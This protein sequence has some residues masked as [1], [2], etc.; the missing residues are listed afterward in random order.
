MIS[1]LIAAAARF[2]EFNVQP[3][4]YGSPETA[5]QNVKETPEWKALY[6]AGVQL[7]SEKQGLEDQLRRKELEI[8]RL[9]QQV[10][11]LEGAVDSQRGA[12]LETRIVKK[13]LHAQVDRLS[14]ERNA[15][16]QENDDLYE[17]LREAI[18]AGYVPAEVAAR[19]QKFGEAVAA[20][21]PQRESAE[22]QEDEARAARYAAIFAQAEEAQAG[23]EDAFLKSLE[24][25]RQ[26]G[27]EGPR[28]GGRKR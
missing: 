14:E 16:L 23:L 15:A 26:G 8:G 2:R 7:I 1:K 17:I 10:R 13:Q 12:N 28:Q 9:Q 3:L 6:E 11:T 25:P 27:P 18:A 21:E 4:T 24:D 20:N 19:H 22:E 5:P